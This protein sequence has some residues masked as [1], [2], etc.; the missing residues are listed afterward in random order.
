MLMQ[1]QHPIAYISKALRP[2][3]HGLSTYEKECSCAFSSSAVEILSTAW[4]V[5][6]CHI[7]Q[8]FVASQ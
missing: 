7:S 5:Y 2:K 8:T 4:R 1:D 3:L 6:Y